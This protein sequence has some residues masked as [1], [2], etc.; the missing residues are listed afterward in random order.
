M[1]YDPLDYGWDHIFEELKTTLKRKPSNGE[2]Q[3]ELLRKF[4]I[5]IEMTDE[6]E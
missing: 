2:V 1:D 4:W 6:N 3:I 5:A